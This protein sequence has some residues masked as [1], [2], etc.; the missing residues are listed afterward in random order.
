VRVQVVVQAAGKWQAGAASRAEVARDR[1][2][3]AAH[4]AARIV[5][6]QVVMNGLNRCGGAGG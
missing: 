3:N 2:R 5:Q 1:P 6:R 4:K